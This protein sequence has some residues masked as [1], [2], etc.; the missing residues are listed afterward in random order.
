MK[1]AAQVLLETLRLQGVD[2][3]FQVP[4]E[5]FLALLDAF[6]DERRVRLVTCRHESG[7]GFMAIA[8]A[9]LTGR[10]GVVMVTRGPGASNAA[11]A[12]HA[13][14]QDAVPLLVLIGQVPR[15]DLG[16][17]ALQEM[18]YR[19]MFG[20]S[21]KYVAEIHDPDRVG[22]FAA[23][24]VRSAF[25]GIPGPVVLSLPEDL[26]ASASEA[27]PVAPSRF[28]PSAA[29]AEAV[30][31]A[32]TRIEGALRPLLIAGGAFEQGQ[33]RSALLRFAEQ[34]Q[35]PVLASFRR[36]DI[37]PNDHPLYAGS[38]GLDIPTDQR[39]AFESADLVFAAGTRLGD[40][41]TLGYTFPLLPQPRQPL[42][43]VHAAPEAIGAMFRAELGVAADP[44]Q[45]LEA[46]CERGCKPPP[47]GRSSW[48]ATLAA[49]RQR[50]ATWTPR[51]AEDGVVQNNVV[52]ALASLLPGDAIVTCDA[53]TQGRGIYNY[54]PFTGERRLL[55]P[56]SGTMGYGVPAGVAAALRFPGRRVVSF[57]G[58]GA[59]LMT[60]PEILGAVQ[61]QVPLLVILGN[62]NSYASV[63]LFQEKAYPGR[64]VGTDLSN[65]DFLSLAK[66]FGCG[67]R[68][69]ARE[70]DIEPV[71]KA[72]LAENRPVIVEVKASLQSVLPG[73][74]RGTA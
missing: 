3:V 60:G 39:A 22:E 40:F 45:F 53:G 8:D 48:I 50:L 16:R 13:A 71:L 67:A 62:N 41:T 36:L 58:D 66:A 5:S 11:I 12:V 10:L 49:I 7:A 27:A 70:E 29:P 32:A 14:Q 69:I 19:A 42:I 1:T 37:F 24:A 18:D 9:R 44:V 46:L 56:L 30:A 2:R 35:V 63:R 6:H 34:W 17:G 52:S 57:V 21:A 15:R 43:H 51:R 68:R 26:L 47:P 64:N 31:A 23:R 72:A 59:F 38:P 74:G 28:L 73:Y 65:P 4:G 33:G 55:G 25:E 61:A 20:Q 54:I